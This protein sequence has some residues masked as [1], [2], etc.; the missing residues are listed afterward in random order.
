[1]SASRIGGDAPPPARRRWRGAAACV[2]RLASAAAAASSA[3]PASFA[4]DHATATICCD[5]GCAHSWAAAG[6][7]ERCAQ[8]GGG[9]EAAGLAA[10]LA[11]DGCGD[12]FHLRCH[13]LTP[14][15]VGYGRVDCARCAPGGALRLPRRRATLA[16][17][18]DGAV[19]AAARGSAAAPRI[20]WHKLAA[21]AAALAAPVRA[22]EAA[23]ARA[24]ES[25]DGPATGSPLC[26]LSGD[27]LALVS[28]FL[29]PSDVGALTSTCAALGGSAGVRLAAF[30]PQLTRLSLSGGWAA[31]DADA[32][33]RCGL[34]PL[35]AAARAAAGFASAPVSLD[36]GLCVR[37]SPATISAL[38]AAAAPTLRSL[39]LRWCRQLDAQAILQILGGEEAVSAGLF[40]LSVE[41]GSASAEPAAASA[42]PPPPAK[43]PRAAPPL[44]PQLRTLDLSG[45]PILGNATDSGL[46][47]LHF[48]VAL[49]TSCP[50]LLTLDVCRSLPSTTEADYCTAA[51]LTATSLYPHPT[52]RL[53]RA[54][55][56]APMTVF[57]SAVRRAGG[58]PLQAVLAAAG[59][60][61]PGTL[62]ACTPAKMLT[63]EVMLSFAREVLLAVMRPRAVPAAELAAVVNLAVCSRRSAL[64]AACHGSACR[65]HQLTVPLMLR[66][67]SAARGDAEDAVAAL[68]APAAATPP[69]APAPAS[70]G[71][72]LSAA[73][74]CSRGAEWAHKLRAIG[75]ALAAHALSGEA[76]VAAAA[77]LA[78]CGGD[79]V[80]ALPADAMAALRAAA[81]AALA[82]APGAGR[83]ARAAPPVGACPAPA[84]LWWAQPD[85]F[86]D[87]AEAALHAPHALWPPGGAARALLERGRLRTREGRLAEA[88]DA[89]EV[90]LALAGD[91]PGA[92]PAA[93]A[94]AAVLDEARK[95]PPPAR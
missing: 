72:A 37:L 40:I 82:L 46:A 16:R 18:R 27:V 33:V 36:L 86:L 93:D 70:L 34:M 3:A 92:T 21:R 41:N 39:S 83:R 22:A 32:A 61:W 64:T 38:V 79:A 80:P 88:G 23:T 44:F 14:L 69:V 9:A 47:I 77:V 65:C 42:P 19:G 17:A 12:W 20:A 30:A 7:C 74:V 57:L 2:R 78:D 29:R 62:A 56:P 55:G 63:A 59:G 11:C 24:E 94:L 13:G 5:C 87:G 73:A 91:G 15:D 52:L 51:L 75:A 66:A 43:R 25:T 90:A 67:A 60:G 1:M 84:G 4:F 31:P 35:L 54:S 58:E 28:A 95:L 71:P 85:L 6:A 89:L 48:F 76:L 8:A 53:V 10:W 45:A 26:E 50:A 81:R 68:R 49:K